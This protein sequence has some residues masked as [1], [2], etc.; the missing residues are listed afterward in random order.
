[1]KVKELKALL[2]HQDDELDVVVTVVVGQISYTGSNCKVEVGRMNNSGDVFSL[3]DSEEDAFKNYQIV[4]QL[5]TFC[6]ESW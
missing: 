1:M 3:E 4:L 5:L 6:G 2:E